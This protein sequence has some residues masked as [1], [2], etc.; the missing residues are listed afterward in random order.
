MYLYIYRHTSNDI[1]EK[2]GHGVGMRGIWGRE[3]RDVN[4]YITNP[5]SR[6]GTTPKLKKKKKEVLYL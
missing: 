1:I 6:K 2:R 4:D 5:P 3:E